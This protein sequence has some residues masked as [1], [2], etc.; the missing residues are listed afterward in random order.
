MSALSLKP[1][2]LRVYRAGIVMAAAWLIH[3]QYSW[4]AAQREADVGL[5][6]VQDYFPEAV[7]IGATDPATSLQKV[8]GSEESLLGYV[9]QTAPIS[10]RFIGYSGP[11]NTLIALDLQK[12]VIA[13]RVL[14]SE[15]TPDHLLEV[16]K[17]RSFFDT[18]KGLKL[19]QLENPPK[20]DAVSGATLTSTA[21]A[22]GVLARLGAQGSSLRF[23]REITLEEVKTL[24]PEADQLTPVKGRQETFEVRDKAGK[25]IA[26][27]TRTAPWSD[28]VVGYK[29]PSD[30]LVLL[31]ADGSKL[32]AIRLRH[33]FDTQEYVGYV[34]GDKFFNNRFNGM[35]PEKL[36]TLDFTAEKIEGVSGATETSWALAEGLKKRAQGWQAESAHQKTWWQRLNLKGQDWGLLAVIGFSLVMT[37]THWRGNRWLRWAHHAALI[38]Y[39]GF[40]GGALLSQALLT[41]WAKHGP[42]WQSAPVLVLLAALA[43]M[44]PLFTRRQFYCHHYCPHGALQQ[45]LAHRVKWQWRIPARWSRLLE[46]LPVLLLVAIFAIVLLGWPVDLNALEAFDAWLIRVA[47]WST[48]IIAVT[49]LIVSLFVPMAYCRYGCPTGVLF[50]FL[51]YAGHADYFGAKDKFALLLVGAAG[52]MHWFM[53]R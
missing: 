50:K 3:A 1:I 52:V 6:K 33:S 47:G 46:K 31:S 8:L 30:T 17:K 2:L 40:Y 19:G 9:T 5:E 22:Q 26:L 43:L 48:I 37:F 27:A 29:G 51:R 12:K 25:T 53:T 41:G 49:G 15:D 38:G 36:S 35:T 13:L 44:L 10:D 39:A 23:P 16:L 42:P 7:A 14:H 28:S 20:V 4:F 21:I 24:K 11:T 18:F 32:E 45:V 34:T